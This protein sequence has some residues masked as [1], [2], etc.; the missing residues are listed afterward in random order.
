[1]ASMGFGTGLVSVHRAS[2]CGQPE[3]AS[4]RLDSVMIWPPAGF[5]SLTGGGV[6]EHGRRYRVR[7]HTYAERLLFCDVSTASAVAE[8]VDSLAGVLGAIDADW[9]VSPCEVS[10][11]MIL[12][13][14]LPLCN[15]VATLKIWSERPI[16]ALC[17]L[18]AWPKV[19]APGYA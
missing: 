18:D 8:I 9:R 2:A 10:G 5:P 4:V 19:W 14:G 7:L 12:P 11:E 16:I 3:R 17:G 15:F 1:M 6:Y 13:E